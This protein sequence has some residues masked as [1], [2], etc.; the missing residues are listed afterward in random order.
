MIDLLLQSKLRENKNYLIIKTIN[1]FLSTML[2]FFIIKY[3]IPNYATNLIIKSCMYSYFISSIF[4]IIFT[5]IEIIKNEKYIDMKLSNMSIFNILLKIYI[6][7]SLS[8]IISFIVNITLSALVYKL[9]IDFFSIVKLMIMN[10]A[11]VIVTGML[12]FIYQYYNINSFHRINLF[13]DFYEIESCVDYPQSSLP[14]ILKQI[15]FLMMFN[16]ITYYVDYNIMNKIIIAFFI[17][18]S[19]VAY[20]GIHMIERN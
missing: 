13:M 18:A 2:V 17:I 1:S 16:L 19:F 5:N 4:E 14:N 7:I 11:I 12:V 9:S 3:F 10:I 8:M 20:I 15:S 6:A